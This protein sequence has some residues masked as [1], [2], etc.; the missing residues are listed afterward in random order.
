MELLC[1]LLIRLND[2]Q[3]LNIAGFVVVLVFYFLVFLMLHKI[4]LSA[5]H[6][7]GLFVLCCLSSS[8][9]IDQNI[10]KTCD[11]VKVLGVTIQSDLKSN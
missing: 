10:L 9:S 4:N 6:R 2:C 11:S 5:A 3:A 7:L 8:L 1:N